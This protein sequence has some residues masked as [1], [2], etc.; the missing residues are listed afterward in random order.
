MVIFLQMGLSFLSQHAFGEK[1][2]P[3]N[4]SLSQCNLSFTAAECRH[5]CADARWTPVLME[6]LGSTSPMAAL[7]LFMAKGVDW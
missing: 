5:H 1:M 4:L 6:M 7:R 2:S 3:P